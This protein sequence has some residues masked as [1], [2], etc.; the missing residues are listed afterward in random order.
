MTDTGSGRERERVFWWERHPD[1]P[2]WKPWRCSVRNIKRRAL[3]YI[4][5]SRMGRL[6]NRVRHG[7]HRA[8]IWRYEPPTKIVSNEPVLALAYDQ[9]WTWRCK[10]CFTEDRSRVVTDNPYY[11]PSDEDHEMD[12]DGYVHG[13]RLWNYA[14]PLFDQDEE[15]AL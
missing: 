7:G 9:Y 1:A 11:P 5:P 2:R 4:H 3:S 15:E 8:L 14:R 13:V 12:D 6:N 10:D